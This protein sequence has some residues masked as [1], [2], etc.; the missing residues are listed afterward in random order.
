[1]QKSKKMGGI[2]KKLLIFKIHKIK[3]K[4]IRIQDLIIILGNLQ[5]MINK[6]ITLIKQKINKIM[7][8]QKAIQKFLLI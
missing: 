1:M 7:F 2:F 5:L 6:I 8:N 3:T 4:K